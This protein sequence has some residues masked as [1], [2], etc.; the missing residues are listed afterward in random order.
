LT[1]DA[2]S[3]NAT[4]AGGDATPAEYHAML[5]ALLIERF[6]LRTHVDTRQAPVRTL[7]LARSDGRLGAGLEPTS[8]ECVQLIADRKSGT[9][10]PP[11]SP[12]LSGALPDAPICGMVMNR[13][14]PS[15]AMTTLYGGVALTQLVSTISSELSTPVVDRT[16]LTGLFDITLAYQSIRQVGSRRAGLDPA[17][18][19]TPPPPIEI[20]LEKQLGLKLEKGT[21]P[22]P[23]LVID[24]AEHPTPD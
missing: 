12:R 16:G 23:F 4:A 17:S 13:S 3:I 24:G 14:G 1:T 8:P 20:A 6:R 18:D 11:T 21:G 7:S 5:E 19:V 22:M 9:A 15:G 2:F 10:P